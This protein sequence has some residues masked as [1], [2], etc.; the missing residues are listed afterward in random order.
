[1]KKI[2]ITGNVGKDPQYKSENTYVSFSVAVSVGTAKDPKT[3]WV[4]V[5]CSGKLAEI[6]MSYVK[7]G[8]KLL[9][10]GFPTVSAYINRDNKAI[11]ALRVYANSI[12][13]LNKREDSNSTNDYQDDGL[14]LKSDDVP[15]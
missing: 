15:F 10:E 3:D 12:E 2:I 9:I 8:S 14:G 1:M 13:I 11:G 4:D 5:S 7:K 6:V